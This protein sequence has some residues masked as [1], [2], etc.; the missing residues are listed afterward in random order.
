[1]HRVVCIMRFKDFILTV[2]SLYTK[3]KEWPKSTRDREERSWPDEIMSL[4]TVQ[5][6]GIDHHLNHHSM[7]GWFFMNECIRCGC[8]S[9]SRMTF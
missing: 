1:M 4:A 9:R 7:A 2:W 8:N 3:Q 5:I 6:I